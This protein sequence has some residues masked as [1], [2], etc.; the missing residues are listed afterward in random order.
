MAQ[1]NRNIPVF[2][3]R[4]PDGTE[5]TL[6]RNQLLPVQSTFRSIPVPAPRKERST[7]DISVPTQENN[8]VQVD[9]ESNADSEVT[10][11]V[12]NSDVAGD[13]SDEEEYVSVTYCPQGEDTHEVGVVGTVGEEAEE[14]RGSVAEPRP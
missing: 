2:V 5:K 9:E 11:E 13:S 6:H 12:R 7:V 1:P 14:V 10:T 8:I 4:A 3:V